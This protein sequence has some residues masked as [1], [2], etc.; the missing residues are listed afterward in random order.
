M[1]FEQRASYTLGKVLESADTRV[2]CNHLFFSS[3][4]RYYILFFVFF[5]LFVCL[6]PHF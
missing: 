1:V 2:G 5:L 6:S 3:S 4:F